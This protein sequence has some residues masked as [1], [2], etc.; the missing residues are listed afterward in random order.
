MFHA[1]NIDVKDYINLTLII[2]LFCH[3]TSKVPYQ[4]TCSSVLFGMS[5]SS[6]TVPTSPR[7]GWKIVVINN[8]VA[9]SVAVSAPIRRLFIFE[10][11]KC[12]RT[13]T[14]WVKKVVLN[15]KINVID[16]SVSATPRN[17]P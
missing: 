7:S 3:Q 8:N 17:V 4:N 16:N 15:N 6:K 12:R 2:Y 13:A 5:A 10:R 14:N 1:N 11:R 9:K